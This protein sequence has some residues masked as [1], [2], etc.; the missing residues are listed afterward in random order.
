MWTVSICN[1]KKTLLFIKLPCSWACVKSICGII[2]FSFPLFNTSAINGIS[3]K[4]FLG[5]L[6]CLWEVPDK[7]HLTSYDFFP[8]GSGMVPTISYP[9]INNTFNLSKP[10]DRWGIE[11][12][13][14][15]N[16]LSF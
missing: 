11:Q 15:K 12:S 9:V 10:V 3:E 6:R 16:D 5:L 13:I 1:F 14:E 4:F 2:F 7:F 8:S